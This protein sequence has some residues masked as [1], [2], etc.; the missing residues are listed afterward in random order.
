[1]RNARWPV[2]ILAAVAIGLLLSF[3]IRPSDQEAPH[4][5]ATQPAR[6]AVANALHPAA[7]GATRVPGSPPPTAAMR[8]RFETAENYAAFIQDAMQRPEEG[9]RFYAWIA[10]VRCMEVARADTRRASAADRGA[11][12][13]AAVRVI[14]ELQHRCRD[15]AAYYPDERAV[16]AALRYS[17]ARGAPDALLNER[18]ALLP[19]SRETSVADLQHAYASNDPYLIAAT[20]DA[21]IDFFAESLGEEFRTG[22][23]RP[24]LYMAMSVAVCEIVG[25]CANSYRALLPCLNGAACESTDYREYVRATVPPESRELFDKTRKRLLQIARERAIPQIAH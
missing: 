10:Y 5:A 14:G 2:L 17:N 8:Q 20:L 21:N 7:P 6:M 25:D 15:V 23:E 22:D 12:L 1:M 9:G 19:P 13:Q 11:V 18:G 16:Q 4:P 3:F 24:L